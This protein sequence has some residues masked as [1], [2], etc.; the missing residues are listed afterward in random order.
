MTVI[1]PI[2]PGWV[3]FQRL[4]LDALPNTRYGS[5]DDLARLSFIHSARWV[6]VDRLRAG[7]ATV[8]PR[9]AHL[10]FESNYNGPLHAYLSAFADVLTTRMR[11]I[12]NSSHGFP[13]SPD[14]EALPLWRRLRRPIPGKAFVD[15][16]ARTDLGADH[17]Y[18][19]YPGAST[20]EILQALD[21][22]AAR[23]SLASDALDHELDGVLARLRQRPPPAPQPTA[24]V[25]D[26]RGH[27]EALTVLTPVRPGAE[28]DLR[29]VLADLSA[30][31]ASPFAS[32]PGTHVARWT[33]VDDLPEQPGHAPDAWP[34][35]YLLT[36]ST[37][38]RE[39]APAELRHARLPQRLRDVVYGHCEEYAPGCDDDG[40]AAY[41]AAHR[42]G[43]QR[44][45]TGYPY[46][47]L[48]TVLDALGGQDELLATI[49]RG[50]AE[51]GS[52]AIRPAS[53]RPSLRLIPTG[54][55]P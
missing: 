29:A 51:A 40:F 18:C 27:H 38:D 34:R 13:N 46:A 12:W 36:S 55:A 6:I 44:F 26:I 9:C 10:L 3:P 49:R 33:L 54:V 11:L 4:V 19:A 39:A 52:A 16:V 28:N 47:R 22:A 20:T 21:I 42:F 23:A 25:G 32:V 15:Y 8:R 31:A 14:G 53:E 45:F 43:A 37:T 2:R 24:S 50:G 48:T 7:G 1:T 17:Y 5:S 41:L 30:G 35:A